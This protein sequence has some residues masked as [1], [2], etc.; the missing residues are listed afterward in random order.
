MH[1][2]FA[3]LSARFACPPDLLGLTTRRPSRGAT[4][5]ASRVRADAARARRWAGGVARDAV[6]Q[7][8]EAELELGS[9]RPHRDAEGGGRLTSRFTEGVADREDADGED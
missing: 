6:E 5:L 2:F 9:A 7:G 3:S 4:R 8:L 1:L